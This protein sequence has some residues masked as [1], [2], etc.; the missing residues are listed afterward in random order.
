[1]TSALRRRTWPAL[2]G[3]LALVVTTVVVALVL[4]RDGRAPF[5]YE[6]LSASLVRLDV[7]PQ[8]QAQGRLDGLLR[9]GALQAPFGDGRVLIGQVAYTEPSDV[10]PVDGQLS[11]VVTDR[12]TGATFGR[13]SG[14][15]P[16]AEDG[17]G[18]GWDGRYE[19]LASRY[20]W[21]RGTASRRDDSG[22][23][24]NDSVALGLPYTGPFTFVVDLPDGLE[25]ADVDV[26]LLLLS[27]DE[28]A[29]AHRFATA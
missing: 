20:P 17:T 7:V 26:T 6:D 22:S 16:R 27:Q 29:W 3:V 8:A 12:R 24:T 2:L 21:L 5:R 18:G 11:V 25:K 19:V 10:A 15:G 13:P 4:R 14:T 23:Y 9:P 28:V 1:M